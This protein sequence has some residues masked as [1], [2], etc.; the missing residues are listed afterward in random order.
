MTA[1]EATI[2]VHRPDDV[3]FTV[4]TDAFLGAI[5]PTDK[6]VQDALNEALDAYVDEHAY[7]HSERWY[8]LLHERDSR[9]VLREALA[10]SLGLDTDEV[11]ADYEFCTGDWE[12]VLSE[13]FGGTLWDTA[14]GRRFLTIESGDRGFMN[15]TVGVRS[16]ECE[17][18]A[19]VIASC[20]QWVMI[21]CTA[22]EYCV[23]TAHERVT[24]TNLTRQDDDGWALDD[25]FCP[26]CGH[27][28][29]AEV[30]I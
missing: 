7:Y 14:D 22:C 20:S 8:S 17:E 21:G 6:K 4:D 13:D 11:S 19:Y 30:W 15:T 2:A 12:S 16:V 29:I 3:T 9:K 23:D 26:R 10:S 24:W 28:M 25:L 18:P 27:R 1:I 5:G